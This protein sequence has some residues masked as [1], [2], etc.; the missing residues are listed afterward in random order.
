MQVGDVRTD[1]HESRKASFLKGLHPMSAVLEPIDQIFRALSDPTRRRVLERLS[2]SPASVSELAEPYDMA[3]PSFVQH[4]KVLEECGLVSSSKSGR[5]RTYR[6]APT[7]LK[8]AE[9]WLGQQR[10]MW[11]KR[12]DRLEEYLLKLK[13]Q[14]DDSNSN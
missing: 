7:Q 10:A 6:I 13:E 3:L 8:L 12:L 9:D 2:T 14:R 5:T 11:E 1:R 4:M